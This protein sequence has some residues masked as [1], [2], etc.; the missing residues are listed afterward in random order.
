MA[1]QVMHPDQEVQLLDTFRKLYKRERDLVLEIAERT[2]QGQI[3]YGPF[4]DAERR[5]L[6]R[7]TLEEIMDAHVYTARLLMILTSKQ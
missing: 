4:E 7:E 6:A 1:L 2:L 5:D 3:K